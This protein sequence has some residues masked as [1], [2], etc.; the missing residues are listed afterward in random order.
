MKQ[1]IELAQSEG[2]TL[3][4][5]ANVDVV[6]FARF[7]GTF[8]GLRSRVLEDDPFVRG[9]PEQFGLRTADIAPRVTDTSLLF[10]SMR[11]M[12]FR[13]EE[14]VTSLLKVQVDLVDGAVESDELFKL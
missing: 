5:I 9:L 14:S 13:D 6:R 11:A 1:L 4:Q 2:V 7:L 3:V 12:D 10:Y 8:L